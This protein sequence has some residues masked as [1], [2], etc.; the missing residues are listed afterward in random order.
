MSENNLVRQFQK[1]EPGSE[2]VILFELK[3]GSAS[4]LCFHSGVDN[5]NANITFDGNTYTAL[6]VEASGFEKT[7]TG[8][9]ARPTIEF[10]N[11]LTTFGD[12]VGT[13]DD[14]LGSVI[15]RR[16]TLNKYLSS[17]PAV[18]FPKETWVIDRV[19]EET[20]LSVT[21]EL[22]AI[23]DL[24]GIT[25]PG[26]QIVANACPWIYQGADH[27]KAIKDKV[28]GCT[29]KRGS[30][31]VPYY[32]T[33]LDQSTSY[34]ALVNI[35]D[36]Y[37]VP[38]SGETGEVTF[39]AYS[40]GAVTINSYYS[41]TT[42]LGTSSGLRRLDKEGAIDTSADSSTVNNY[43]QAAKSE[44]SPG[45]P[46]DSNINFKRIRIWDTWSSSTTYYAYTNDNYNDYVRYTETSDTSHPFYNIATLWKAK[47]TN[48]NQAPGFNDYWELGDV[49]SKSL[50]GCKMRYGFDPITANNANSTAKVASD[51]SV[52]L[53]F[54]GFP[55]ARGFT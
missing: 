21:F 50:T 15:T 53:P 55:G 9:A 17:S 26:R 54:G 6:P 42:T 30:S 24:E 46:S 8:A 7:T 28:G 13:Y 29:W 33:E 11:V 34:I 41:T 35:D 12:A 38:G 51:T 45:T 32:K 16:I 4:P 40:S 14:L 52:V 10:A 48:L 19:K 49:C 31:Y 2:L 36:E 47:K 3:I 5:S 27:T 39:S 25:L 43:W 20:K 1:L 22:A 23:F 44:S 18:E 37:L